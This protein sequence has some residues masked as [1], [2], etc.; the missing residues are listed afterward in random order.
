MQGRIGLRGVGWI[1]KN[2]KVV[3]NPIARLGHHFDYPLLKRQAGIVGREVSGG[4]P[5]LCLAIKNI[6]VFINSWLEIFGW[7]KQASYNYVSIF[8]KL[9]TDLLRT[10]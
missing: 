7:I 5:R 9:I 8:I 6:R 3:V 10:R 1:E 2:P 4:M